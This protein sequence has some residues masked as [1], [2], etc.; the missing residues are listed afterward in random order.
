MPA[1]TQSTRHKIGRRLLG[2]ACLVVSVAVAGCSWFD[3]NEDRYNLAPSLEMGERVPDPDEPDEPWA[4]TNE[5]RQI[6]DRL[7]SRD[8]RNVLSP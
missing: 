7:L 8:R 5:G 2:V 4:M 3:F 1:S 6:E